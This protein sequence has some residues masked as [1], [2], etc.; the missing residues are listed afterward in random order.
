MPTFEDALLRLKEQLGTPTDKVAAELLGLT[1]KSLNARKRRNSF[2]T[3]EVFALA[4]QRPDLGLDPDWIVTGIGSQQETAGND[5]ASLI[6]CYRIMSTHDRSML[7]K[8]AVA[9]SGVAGLSGDEISRRL[10]NYK[11]TK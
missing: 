3:K 7:L 11:P 1:D 8:I 2:P 6:Q 9:M 5:E 10:A 4:A